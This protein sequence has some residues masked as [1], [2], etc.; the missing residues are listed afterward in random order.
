MS[1][2]HDAIAAPLGHLVIAFNELE[3]ALGGA[4]MRLLKYEDDEIGSAFVAVLGF[5]QKHTLLKTLAHKITDDSVRNQFIEYLNNAKNYSEMRNRYIH[6]EY[7]SVPGIDGEE[8]TF[9]HQRLKD[10]A[11]ASRFRDS[12]DLF[13]YVRPTEPKEIIDLADHTA[14]LAFAMLRLSERF[15]F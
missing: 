8:A 9:L 14:A 13:E 6:A 10:F 7:T 5:A 15:R 11:K 2:P 1:D 3:V 4:L 12:K